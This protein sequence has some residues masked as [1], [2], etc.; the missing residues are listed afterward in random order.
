AHCERQ[1]AG[2]GET[3]QPPLAGAAG[4]STP[5]RSGR[6][7]RARCISTWIGLVAP[8]G[9]P[10]EI[11][12][13]IRHEIMDSYADRAIAEKLEKSGISTATSTPEEFSAFI[14]SELARWS[15][16][17]RESGIEFN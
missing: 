2:A 12:D 13:K 10:R 9:T 14:A 5:R 11:I 16:V 8:A 4:C 1:I 6:D 17:I 3:Q 7:S 15:A